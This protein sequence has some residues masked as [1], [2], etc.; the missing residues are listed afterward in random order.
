MFTPQVKATNKLAE[1]VVVY[2]LSFF[3]NLFSFK[4]FF[5]TLVTF[6]SSSFSLRIC[7]KSY[8]LLA[9]G[10]RCSIGM[11]DGGG[12]FFLLCLPLAP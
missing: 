8:S 6:F 2:L 12:V 9:F 1:G 4:P 10:N 3:A 5:F 11:A 7:F